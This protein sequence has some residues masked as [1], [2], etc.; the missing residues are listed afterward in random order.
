MLA[1]SFRGFNRDAAAA[2]LTDAKACGP[3]AHCC[4]TRTWPQAGT[5][6]SDTRQIM[7][8]GERGKLEWEHPGR[9]LG[10]ARTR[11]ADGGKKVFARASE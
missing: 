9:L 7:A 3:N 11:G 5:T 4:P 2:N 8:S 6:K 1:C 10:S